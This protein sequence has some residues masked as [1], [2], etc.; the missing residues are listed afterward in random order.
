MSMKKFK[1]L[2]KEW[3]AEVERQCRKQLSPEK[4]KHITS[5]M[6]TVY[7]NCPDKKT[8][9]LFYRLVDGKVDSITL[10]EGTMPKAEFTI[11]ADYEIFARISRAE[12]K[13]R[14]AL[15]S[16]KMNLKGNLV[17]ALTL[18]PTVDRLNEVLASVPTEY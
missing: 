1:Y 7:T 6:L 16:G 2:S 4:M 9:A 17:K 10:V 11:T 14:A 3:T 13:A 12:L 18:A 5:S 15:M 8:H